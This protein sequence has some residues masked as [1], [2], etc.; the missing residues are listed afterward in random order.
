MNHKRLV[1]PSSKQRVRP[2]RK[3][4][5][6]LLKSVITAAVVALA[7]VAS[8]VSFA[9]AQTLS[10]PDVPTTSPFYAAINELAERGIVDGYAN[11]TFGPA[12]NVMRQQFAK[13]IVLAAGYPVS[14]ADVSPFK[15]VPVSGPGN[16]YA[17]NYIAVAAAKGITNGKT[18]TRFDP[19]AYITRYQVITMVV[20]TADSLQPALLLQP[21]A[22]YAGTTGWGDDPIHGGN[23]A[24]AEYNSLLA[25][26]DL[27]VSPYAPMTRGEVAQVLYNLLAKL[28]PVPTTTTTASPTTTTS[29]STTTSA[30]TTTTTPSTTTAPSSTTTAP[31]ATTSTTSTTLAGVPYATD[32]A[33]AGRED[34]TLTPTVL[35]QFGNPLP[36]VEVFFTSEILE[37]E[38]LEP[39]GPPALSIGITDAAGNVAYSWGH[40]PGDWG[41]ERVTAWVDNGTPEGLT[42]VAAVIQWIYD[43]TTSAGDGYIS[44]AAGHTTATVYSGFAEWSGLTVRAHLNP[45]TPSVGSRL[46]VPSVD[47]SLSTSHTWMAGQGVFVGADSTNTDH[48]RNWIYDLVPVSP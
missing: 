38:G 24:R 14:E 44:A 47:L 34:V 22:G 20:R 37:G 31:P 35:D 23:A 18:A 15:D 33:I 9:L 39:I 43:D 2:S 8:T 7:L 19:Y 13:M 27:T 36:G 46:Y 42:S 1:R 32:Y 4:R 45:R 5:V 41:V 11:G 40:D 10:F 28:T 3:Q 29:S 16:L 26:L 12:D 17:D 25:G 48:K 6:R 21:P 30:S